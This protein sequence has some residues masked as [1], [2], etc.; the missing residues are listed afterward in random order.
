LDVSGGRVLIVEGRINSGTLLRGG[1]T[2]VEVGGTQLMQV[3]VELIFPSSSWLSHSWGCWVV[4]C[5]SVAVSLSLLLLLVCP[6]PPLATLF[7]VSSHEQLLTAVVGLHHPTMIH[8]ANSGEQWQ[9][10]SLFLPLILVVLP[11]STLRAGS[12][13]WCGHRGCHLVFCQ[14]G[15]CNVAGKFLPCGYP[16]SLGTLTPPM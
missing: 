8:P 9:R 4:A 15:S 16:T 14:L 2:Q 13:W 6:F 12:Q 10:G 11:V 1:L 5:H 7:P 3:E